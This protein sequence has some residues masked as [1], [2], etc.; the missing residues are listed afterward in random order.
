MDWVRAS[1]RRARE[2]SNF[3][4]FSM[5][6]EACAARSMADSLIVVIVE[7]ICSSD[8]RGLA[9]S[10]GGGLAIMDT[11]IALLTDLGDTVDH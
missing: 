9:I 6:D 5:R 4:A 10:D 8:G 11:K 2:S 1:P 7:R 3:A